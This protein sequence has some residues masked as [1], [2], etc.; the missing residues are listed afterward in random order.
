MISLLGS[1]LGF[2]SS[3]VGPVLEAWNKS[4]DQTLE[5]TIV[6]VDMAEIVA[7][8]KEQAATVRKGPVWLAASSGSV[9]LVVTYLIIIGFLAINWANALVVIAEEGVTVSNLR[10]IL[11]PD[12]I[13]LVSCVVAFGLGTGLSVSGRPDAIQSDKRRSG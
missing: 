10:A 1:L 2:G 4:S 5:A 8:H 13:G 7:T 9:R 11:D 3:L 12:F 6:E